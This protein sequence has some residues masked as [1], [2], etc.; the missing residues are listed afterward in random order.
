MNEQKKVSGYKAPPSELEKDWEEMLN[1]LRS[2]INTANNPHAFYKILLSVEKQ[3]PN[4]KVL[5]A[6]LAR[7]K[8]ECAKENTANITIQHAR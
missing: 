2:L 1:R 5:R 4:K 8:A 3:Q 6:T 7:I